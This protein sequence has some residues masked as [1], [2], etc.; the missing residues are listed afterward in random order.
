M[1]VTGTG[2]IEGRRVEPEAGPPASQRSPSSAA[3]P[4]PAPNMAANP[5]QPWRVEPADVGSASG[6]YW[7]GP[8]SVGRPGD[9]G[10]GGP[11]PG[12]TSSGGYGPAAGGPPWLGVSRGG[13]LGASVA[14]GRGQQLAAYASVPSAATVG[15]DDDQD[16]GS[17]RGGEGPL[18]AVLD[19]V[20]QKV[21]R[22]GSGL[23]GASLGPSDRRGSSTTTIPEIASDAALAELRARIRED[24]MAC[25]QV[26]RLCV[27]LWVQGLSSALPTLQLTPFAALLPSLWLRRRSRRSTWP[28]CARSWRS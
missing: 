10:P 15:D 5:M 18:A 9:S 27:G 6:V 26:S 8:Y 3:C 11:E 21:E 22:H 25:R 14:G 1:S 20:S 23:S 7:P 13:S 4:L 24:T 12:P 28:L 2:F 16:G 17:E 19:L